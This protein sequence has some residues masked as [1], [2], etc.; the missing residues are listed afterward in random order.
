M[1]FFD[2]AQRRLRKF[3][4]S[5]S[6]THPQIP[7]GSAQDRGSEQDGNQRTNGL[8]EG[9]SHSGEDHDNAS[10][11]HPFNR[12]SDDNPDTDR[13]SNR[14]ASGDE[15][16]DESGDAGSSDPNLF[17]EIHR[18]QDIGSSRRTFKVPTGAEFSDFHRPLTLP[19]IEDLCRES[20]FPVIGSSLSHVTVL[21][22]DLD[23]EIS[24]SDGAMWLLIKTSVEIPNQVTPFPELD[25]ELTDR[26]IDEQLH[27]LIDATNAWN[28]QHFLPTA[29]VDRVEDRWVVRLDSAFFA[30]AGMTTAQF[31]SA[32][33]R[34][35]TFSK[36]AAEE[37][38]ALIPPI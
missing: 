6:D 31:A 24:L 28:Q 35:A 4:G 12:E 18:T 29:Y 33:A 17:E 9:Y 36:Q 25:G 15:S 8:H 5:E 34:A 37:I 38:P 3:V 7:D 20:P 10:Y 1:N 27:L 23:L 21:I 32:L 30:G 22:N 14:E 16:T 2:R 19:V 13:E 11:E 26:Q